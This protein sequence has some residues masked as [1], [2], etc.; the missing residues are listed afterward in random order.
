MIC[1]W[2]TM[3]FFVDGNKEIC[4]CDG[5]MEEEVELITYFRRL[6]HDQQKMLLD[7]LKTI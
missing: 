3:S 4:A 7:L 6:S 2:L 5:L 1:L